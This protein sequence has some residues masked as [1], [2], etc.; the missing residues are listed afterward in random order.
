MK[1]F[2]IL[3]QQVKYHKIARK[4]TIENITNPWTGKVI[5][6]K[7]RFSELS[8][9]KSNDVYEESIIDSIVKNYFIK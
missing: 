3:L 4:T 2:V 5:T 8:K 9:T 6:K 1:R 7:D